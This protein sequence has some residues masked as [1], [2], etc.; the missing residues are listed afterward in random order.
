MKLADA[1]RAPIVVPGGIVWQWQWTNWFLAE[2]SDKPRAISEAELDKLVAKPDRY[3]KRRCGDGGCGPHGG[4][5]D[6][7]LVE[8]TKEQVVAKGQSEISAAELAGN[9]VV[10]ATF[11]AYGASGGVYRTSIA[12]GEAK[13]LWDGAITE[14]LIDKTDVYAAG[15]GGVAWIDLESA[16]TVVLDASSKETRTL[17]LGTDRIFWADV[18]D[19]YHGSKPSG[20]ILSA[21]RHGGD[22]KTH[23]TEQPWPETIVVDE[24]QV[25]WASRDRGGI[26]SVG[27]TGGSV[28]V[29]VPTDERCGGVMWLHRIPRGLLFLRGDAFEFRFGGGGEM[30]F[31]PLDPMEKAKKQQ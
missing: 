20:R 17:A 12:G 25:Y 22:V 28:T 27:I 2:D 18:G 21:P 19:P 1:S 5:I 3:L 13:K 8:G 29:L 31:V 14:L 24:R 6:L 30:W 9:E 15:T 4:N 7:V 16:K 23:A 11:G 10:F 26:W